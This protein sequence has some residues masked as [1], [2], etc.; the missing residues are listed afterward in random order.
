MK[1]PENDNRV[2]KGKFWRLPEWFSQILT[3]AE[4]NLLRAYHIELLHFNTRLNLIS[5]Q[6]ES[7][8]DLVHFS[9]SVLGSKEILSY[10][11]KD[12]IYDIGSGNGFP[13]VVLAILAPNRTIHLIDSDAR[14]IE[15]LKHVA[16]RLGLKNLLP[17]HSR[18]EDLP[19]ESIHCAVSRG[20]ASIGRT[21]LLSRKACAVDCD[22]FHF[23]SSSWVTEVVDIPPQVCAYWTPKLV[24]EYDL[25][26]GY[27][28]LSVVVT[29]KIV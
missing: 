6:T 17:R 11:E 1:S 22:Y 19:K 29:K 15:F 25:P 18:L 14:K 12:E 9:D 24:E 27:N 3:E 28:K 16:H 8:A 4:L 21:L 7:N 13:G 5:V 26:G 23:K 20:L 2:T 10:T